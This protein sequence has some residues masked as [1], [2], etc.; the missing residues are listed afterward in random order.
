MADPMRIRAALAGDETTVRVL[1]SHVMEPGTRKDASGALIPAHFIQ[2]VEA[3][4]NGKSVLK[5]MWSGAVSQNPF[6]SFKFKGA[7]KGDKV[8]VKWSDNKGESRSDE[9]TIA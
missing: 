5:A 2:D 1:M 9:A 3:T 7:A 6:L 8:T 4:H